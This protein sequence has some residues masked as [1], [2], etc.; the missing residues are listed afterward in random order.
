[1]GTPT[2]GD[3]VAALTY[4]PLR[5]WAGQTISFSIPRAG[6]NWTD[7]PQRGAGWSEYYGNEPFKPD[8]GVLSSAQA[9]VFRQAVATWQQ[10]MAVRLVET[11]DVASP[12]QIRVAFTGIGHEIGGYAFVP[13]LMGQAAQPMDGDIWL[14]ATFKPRSLVPGYDP[15][16]GEWPIPV[17]LHEL[18]HALGLQHSYEGA[19]RLL[20]EYEDPRYTIMSQ[21]FIVG[22]GDV[23]PR[24]AVSAG[25]SALTI[26]STTLAVNQPGIF[27]ILALQSIYGANPDTAAGDTT[28][29]WAEDEAF[30]LS[31][32]DAGGSDTIDLSRHLRASAIDLTPGHFS[33]IGIYSAEQQTADWIARFPSFAG[34]ITQMMDAQAASKRLYTGHDNV[35]IAFNTVIENVHAGSGDDTVTGNAASNALNGGPGSDRLFGGDGADTVTDPSGSNYLRGDEGADSIVGG[36]GFDD[37]NGNMGND[38]CVSGG[39]D[40]WVVGGRDNDSLVGSAGQNLVYGNLGNDTCEGGDGNDIVR[41]GQ[42]NDVIFGGAGDDYVSGDKGADTVTGGAGADI[43][44]TFGDA[45]LDRVLDF[46]LAQGDRVQVDPGTQYSVSQVGADTV[47]DMTGGGQMVLVGVQI[48]TLTTGWI[49]GA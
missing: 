36:S 34:Q 33:S 30:W 8:Y 37:I 7:Y 27:D 47:I 2:A 5:G 29:A 38:T 48:S 11:D 26:D 45:G 32:Y 15:A 22:G 44:H 35:G 14:D 4:A 25:G 28:Y 31:L 18:G 20:G 13:P 46:N 39:G 10:F 12:G 40:D 1:M 16:A 23:V 21:A 41:G 3:I 24:F 43:F 42:D 17:L 49:L 9:D 6:S 19:V